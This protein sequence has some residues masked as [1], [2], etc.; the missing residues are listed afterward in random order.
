[1]ATRWPT[2]TQVLFNCIISAL[3]GLLFALVL[4][5]AYILSYN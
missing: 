1:M 2:R 4:F 5:G 3:G